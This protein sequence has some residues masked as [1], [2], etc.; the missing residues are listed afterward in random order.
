MSYRLLQN[1]PDSKFTVPMP[2]VSIEITC[3]VANAAG[4]AY[5]QVSMTTE[6][7]SKG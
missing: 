4:F 5:D 2:A 1:H 6:K 3:P 7:I